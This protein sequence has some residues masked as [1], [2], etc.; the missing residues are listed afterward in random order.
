MKEDGH[1]VLEIPVSSDIETLNMTMGKDTGMV[2]FYNV[3]LRDANDRIIVA[4]KAFLCNGNM[5]RPDVYQFADDL[6]NLYFNELPDDAILHIEYQV[7]FG[8]KDLLDMAEEQLHESEQKMQE[9]IDALRDVIRKI[10]EENEGLKAQSEQYLKDYNTV[11]NSAA[12]K[13]TKPLRKV[14]DMMKGK[15]E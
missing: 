7:G 15:S 8:K 11:I 5:I 2:R 9:E 10:Q 1:S 12:W 13:S 14:A 4:N 6:P 3:S